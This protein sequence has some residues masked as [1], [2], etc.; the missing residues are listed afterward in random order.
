[1][2]RPPSRWPLCHDG[3][4]R[5]GRHYQWHWHPLRPTSVAPA[6]TL[7]THARIGTPVVGLHV[8]RQLYHIAHLSHYPG[9]MQCPQAARSSLASGDSDLSAVWSRCL[10]ESKSASCGSGDESKATSSLKGPATGPAA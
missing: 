5:L 10:S 3:G 4:L 7:V 6:P 2:E 9:H 1:M 8:L